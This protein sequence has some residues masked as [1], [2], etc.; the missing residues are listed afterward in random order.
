MFSLSFID[1]AAFKKHVRETIISYINNTKSVDLK[2]FNSNVIDPIK[3]LFDKQ[4]YGKS[5]DEILNLEIYR[6]KDKSNTNAIGYFH[7]NIF[8]Y[9]KN[10]SVPTK[11]WDIIFQG[12]GYQ[13]FVEM[14][15]KHNTM[16][17]SSAQK[18]YIQMQHKILQSPNDYCFL[19]EVISPVSRN[20]PWVCSVNGQRCSNEHIRKVSVDK[21][22][23]IVTGVEDAF[24]QVCMQLPETLT[25]L[26]KKEDMPDLPK[27][28]TVIE[29][30]HRENSDMLK[31]LY[32]LA[33]STYN[34]FDNLK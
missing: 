21:F 30:L 15:N 33:F 27:N 13:I 32:L 11:G 23:Q 9:I 25:E 8:K 34:G 28:D 24:Y 18:T 10:C 17:S 12:E 1:E 19:V 29:E 2:S 3:L 5:F 20:I 22:Y 4:I 31:A 7:Q 14:K 26:L 6:Q 16:N